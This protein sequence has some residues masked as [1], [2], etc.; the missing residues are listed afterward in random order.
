MIDINETLNN[1]FLQQ[2]DDICNVQEEDM[3]CTVASS[4]A[5]AEG[6]LAVLSCLRTNVSHIYFGKVAE[7]LGFDTSK[8]YQKVQ[9]VWEEEIIE[10]IHPDD[11][12]LC[13]L[14]ELMFHKYSMLMEQPKG[15][16]PWHMENTMRMKDSNGKWLNMH[17]RIFYFTSVGKPGVSYSLCIYNLTDKLQPAAV[18]LDTING[19]RKIIK[20]EDCRQILSDREKNILILIRSGLA[21]KEIGDRLN[22]SKH[23][24]DR[25]RQNIIA[26]LQVSNA[27]EACHKAK[28][29]GLIE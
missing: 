22:I 29:L 28:I 21:S 7:V 18:M 24:V 14:Q 6:A 23:T 12:S 19:T 11:W 9:S 25:H 5:F 4:Y 10:R 16:Y 15:V 2:K 20:T 8:T 26:K 3:L 1:K 13:C 27:T 17:H